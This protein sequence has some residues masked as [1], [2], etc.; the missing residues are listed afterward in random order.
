MIFCQVAN[1]GLFNFRLL[2]VGG[3]AILY[4]HDFATCAGVGKRGN[5]TFVDV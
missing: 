4:L 3:V 5:I 2:F 1:C